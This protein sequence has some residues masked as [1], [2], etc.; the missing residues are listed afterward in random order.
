[1]TPHQKTLGTP[2]PAAGFAIGV[3]LAVVSFWLAGMVVEMRSPAFDA[4]PVQ[5]SAM[6]VTSCPVGADDPAQCLPLP[7]TQQ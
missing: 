3:T 5:A 1:M 6:T 7:S 4:S 2:H